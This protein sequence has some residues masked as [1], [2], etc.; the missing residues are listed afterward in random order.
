MVRTLE[1]R[2]AYEKAFLKNNGGRRFGENKDLMGTRSLRERRLDMEVGSRRFS[3][4]EADDP[5][6]RFISKKGW[7]LQGLESCGEPI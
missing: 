2:K 7:K 4:A 5:V 3:W 1:R 6:M